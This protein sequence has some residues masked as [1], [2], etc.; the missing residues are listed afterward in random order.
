MVTPANVSGECC[1]QSLQ[2]KQKQRTGLQIQHGKLLLLPSVM[3]MDGGHAYH[4]QR[5]AEE[6]M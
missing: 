2:E 1:A 3:A 6:G 5:V 4:L